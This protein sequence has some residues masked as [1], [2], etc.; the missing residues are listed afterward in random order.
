MGTAIHIEIDAL[1]LI[2]L[3][4]I[5]YQSIRNVSQQM[6]RVLFRWTVYGIMCSLALDIIWMLI[7]GVKLPGLFTLNK[8]VNALI[9]A[10]GI[11]I[12][13]VWYLY[14]LETLGYKITRTLSLC[15]MAPGFLFTALNLVSM[16]TGWTFY[17]SEDNVYM[18]GPLF[19][20]QSAAALSVLLVSL[21]HILIRL[22][23]KD[24]RAPRTEVI[25]L[26]QFYILPVIGTVAALPFSGMPGTWT[27]AAVSI[28]LIYL[29]AQDR[30]IVRDSLT[31]LN[32]RKMLG[33]V[34]ADYARQETA[35]A[36]LYLFMMDLDDF[37]KINDTLG[38]PIGDQA[39]KAASKL[40]IRAVDGKRAMVARVGGDE[41]L[42]MGF[43]QDDSQADAFCSSIRNSFQEYNAQHQLP[44]LL[45]I[46]I[47]YSRYEKGYTLDEFISRADEKLYQAKRAGKRK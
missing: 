23:N 29:D 39:L 8:V 14:V 9:L 32:N 40:L 41:F 16:K 47:G 38:H 5:A 44:Y 25:K 6:S 1:F 12:G 15:V 37:K 11:V 19:W 21:F 34:F 33:Q 3:F 28:V 4:V 35:N 18:R 45:A 36:K 17:V 26:L 27:C 2:I 10:S 42:I 13:C 22:I 7:D 43:F 24:T 46:S 30:E 20:L 31:G